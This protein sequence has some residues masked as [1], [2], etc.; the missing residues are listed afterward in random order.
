MIKFYKVGSPFGEFSNFSRFGFVDDEG[1]YWPTSEHYFQA[2]KFSSIELKEK[3][4]L[5]H[6]PMEAAM[7][8]RNPNNP[9]RS[10]WENIKD[11]IMYYAVYQKICQNRTVKELLLSTE[12][13]EIIEHTINDSYWGDG[14]DGSGLNKLGEILMKVRKELRR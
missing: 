3:I 12:D 14:G 11:E 2:Q 9:L 13:E 1:K 10:D 8:G 6:S 5:F 7:E 4:R